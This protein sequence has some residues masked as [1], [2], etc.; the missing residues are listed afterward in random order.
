MKKQS[1]NYKTVKVDGINIFYREAGDP[2]KQQI[3]LLNGVPNASSAFQDLMNDLKEDYYMVAP[4]FPGFG[5]SDVPDKKVY[6]YTFDNIS[7]TIESFMRVIGLK[8]PNVYAL[9]YGGPITFRIGTRS[10]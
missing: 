6:E 2:S 4:D 9:G 10:P 3:I 1:I 5:H 8:H 7:K